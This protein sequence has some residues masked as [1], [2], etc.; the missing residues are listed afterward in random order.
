MQAY[1]DPKRENDKY[2][3]PDLEVW[4]HKHT[5]GAACPLVSMGIVAGDECGGP[6]WYYW[7]C[8][9]GC[10]PDSDPMGPFETAQAALKDARMVYD[11]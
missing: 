4:E 8:L 10:L 11:E 7:Y 5:I 3:L 2:S 1:S 6:G 9:P